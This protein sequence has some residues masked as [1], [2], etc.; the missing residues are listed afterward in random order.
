MKNFIKRLLTGIVYT[1]VIAFGVVY[2]QYTFLAL[3][4]TIIIL[5]S[6]E[7][8]RLI[9]FSGEKKIN[10]YLHG[11]GGALLFLTVFLYA[12]GICGRNIFSLYLLYILGTMIYELYDKQKSSINRLAY[13]ILGQ[14][15]IALPFAVLNLLAFPFTN[16]NPPVYKCIWII[17]LF[18][19]LW[20]ND[21]GAYLI[22][23]RFGEHR[24]WER[25]S[26]KKSWEGFFGGL[27]FTII[28]AFAFIYFCPEIAWYHWIA[29]SVGVVIFGTYGD[30]FESLIKRSVE[31]KDSGRLLPGHGGF[32]DRFDSLLF[33]VYAMLFYLQIF[34]LG[35]AIQN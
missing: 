28:S 17:A 22:G 9:N 12:S 35:T 14:C 33:A 15:Y 3:F 13:I 29:L 27:I 1:G 24:L 7:F 4:M 5:C 26:P 10:T 19:F 11:A 32:L 6:H 2:S 21:T 31:A 8:Y 18:V 30:L 16:V 25:I 23:V 20:A 34:S